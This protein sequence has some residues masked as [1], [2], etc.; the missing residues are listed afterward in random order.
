[1]R[2]FVSGHHGYIGTIMSRLLREAGHT[3]CGA[4][5]YLYDDCTFGSDL[6]PP[7]IGLKR[8][9]REITLADIEGPGLRV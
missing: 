6:L 3:V 7:A 5:M 9:I 4:D 2:V 8:D 1:M